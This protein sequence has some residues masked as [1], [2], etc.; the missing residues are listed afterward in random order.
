MIG[1]VLTDLITGREDLEIVAYSVDT[2]LTAI[3]TDVS[4]EID[5]VEE[6]TQEQFDELLV[7]PTWNHSLIQAEI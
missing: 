1:I 2:A 7:T 3:N 5:L 6:L 4:G